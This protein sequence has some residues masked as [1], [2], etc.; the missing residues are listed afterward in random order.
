MIRLAWLSPSVLENLL[1][2]RQAPT[3]SIKEMIEVADLP[4]AEQ[5]ADVFGA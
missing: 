5:E 3:V 1:L 4:W 2:H